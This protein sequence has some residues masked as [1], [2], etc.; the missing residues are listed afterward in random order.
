MEARGIMLFSWFSIKFKENIASVGQMMQNKA[1][2]AFDCFI[3][4]NSKEVL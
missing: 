1:Y 2:L 4:I 3:G